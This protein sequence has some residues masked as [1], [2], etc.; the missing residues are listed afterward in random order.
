MKWI[1]LLSFFLFYFAII[2]ISRGNSWTR[3]PEKGNHLAKPTCRNLLLQHPCIT[4]SHSV[5]INACPSFTRAV[6][7]IRQN[8]KGNGGRLCAKLSLPSASIKNDKICT[9]SSFG[10]IKVVAAPHPSYRASWCYIAYRGWY[11]SP[12][13]APASLYIIFITPHPPHPTQRLVF[14]LHGSTFFQGNFL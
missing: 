11:C 9:F 1:F 10:G 8:R 4:R 6:A 12:S 3:F 2:C 5:P 7:L 13:L 14:I